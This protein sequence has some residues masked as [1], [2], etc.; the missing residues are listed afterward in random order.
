MRSNLSFFAPAHRSAFSDVVALPDGSVV[1]VGS[2]AQTATRKETLVAK[3]TPAGAIDTSFAAPT[4]VLHQQ[5]GSGTDD[6][7]WTGS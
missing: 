7:F 4:G 5:L 3:Y 6:S 2:D 1:A